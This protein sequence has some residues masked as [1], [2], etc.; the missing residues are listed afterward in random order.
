MHSANFCMQIT[1]AHILI[2]FSCTYHR[3]HADNTFTFY[4]SKTSITVENMPVA[5]VQLHRKTIMIFYR[6]TVCEHELRLQIVH[7]PQVGWSTGAGRL[8]VL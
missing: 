8:G 2:F 1:S 5:A 4:F 3:L 7:R 6:N